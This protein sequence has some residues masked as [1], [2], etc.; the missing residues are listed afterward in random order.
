MAQTTTTTRKV[1]AGLYDV[2]AAGTTYRVEEYYQEGTGWVWRVTD[3]ENYFDPWVG[4]ENT[5]RAAKALV[6][7]VA[8]R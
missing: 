5:L 8:G 7:E 3:P 6:A 1:R 4:D 2:T